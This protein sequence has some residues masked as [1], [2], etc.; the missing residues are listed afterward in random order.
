MFSLISFL[1]KLLS[2]EALVMEKITA[3]SNNQTLLFK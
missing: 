2:H 1:K 3:I